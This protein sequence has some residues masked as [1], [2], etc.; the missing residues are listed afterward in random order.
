MDIAVAETVRGP[1][2]KENPGARRW[3]QWGFNVTPLSRSAI[4]VGGGTGVLLFLS[5][6]A[7]CSQA[8]PA[9]SVNRLRC[10]SA[11]PRAL[12][13]LAPTGS[14]P[15]YVHRPTLHRVNGLRCES[16]RPAALKLLAA[17]AATVAA[18]AAADSGV[19]RAVGSGCMGY[20]GDGWGIGEGAILHDGAGVRGG[21]AAA[22]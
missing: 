16:A 13:Q 21:G 9:L 10:E 15:L 20:D 1:P 7:P 17:Q 5:A 18:A 19:G 14:R 22:A 3:G 4:R 8:D 6:T 11:R 2:I 12:K